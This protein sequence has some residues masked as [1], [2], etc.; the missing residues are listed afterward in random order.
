[1][2]DENN[3]DKMTQ[4]VND[5]NNQAQGD[6]LSDANTPLIQEI[7]DTDDPVFTGQ[8]VQ[9]AGAG[10][11]ILESIIETV[12]PKLDKT[13]DDILEEGLPSSQRVVPQEVKAGRTKKK[14]PEEK[15]ETK[16]K[17]TDPP[18]ET[19]EVNFVKPTTPDDFVEVLKRQE[20]L[21][22]GG[23]PVTSKSPTP[24]QRQKGVVQARI[25]TVNT[26]DEEKRALE[27]AAYDVLSK[28]KSFKNTTVE[29]LHKSA[30]E[31]GL[32]E[33]EMKRITQGLPLNAKIGDYDLSK[34]IAAVK[35]LY[36]LH[37]EQVDALMKKY[38]QGQNLGESK[39][40][41]TEEQYNLMVGMTEMA[42][43][44]DDLTQS[45]REIG[46]ALNA[47]KDIK[48]LGPTVKMDDLERVISQEMNE[49]AFDRFVNLYENAGNDFAR[50]ALINQNGGTFRHLTDSAYYTFQSNLLNN[51]S[52]WMDNFIGSTI[53]GGLMM[54]EDAVSSI[55]ISPLTNQF[56]RLRKKPVPD[57][58]A[59][60]DDVLTGLKGFWAGIKDG[61]QGAAHVIRT[62]E[63]QG[64]KGNRYDP[65]SSSRIP[66]ELKINNPLTQATY[67]FNTSEL[68]DSWVGK[69]IDGIGFLQ[70]IPMKALAAGDEIVG[71]TIARMALHKEGSIY[72]KNR[73]AQLRK[74][75]KTDEEIRAI[76]TPEVNDFVN[77]QPADIFAN[78][79]EHKDMIQFT[80]KWDKTM[81]LDKAYAAVNKTL[82]NPYIRFMVPFANTLTKIFDQGASRIPG[83]NFIS[84]QF[85]K[86]VTRGGKHLDRA[87]SR[88]VVGGTAL[89]MG[90]ERASEGLMTGSGPAN[91]TDKAALLKTGWQPYSFVF[92]KDS[93]P[94][95]VL[96]KIGALTDIS[97]GNGKIYISYQRFD[98]IAPIMAGAADLFD[99]HRLAGEDVTREDSDNLF[100]ALALSNAE[101][102]QNLPVMQ[103]VS[104][105]T[106]AVGGRYEDQGEKILD[107]IERMTIAT[108]RNVMLSIPGVGLTQS[109]AARNIAKVID[110]EHKSK[111][112]DDPSRPIKYGKDDFANEVI[113]KM[114][115]TVK[116]STPYFR[117]T[118]ENELDNAGRPIYNL[119]TMHEHW[120]NVIPSMRMT[121]ER[122]SPMDEVLAENY[123]GI[124]QAS[125]KLDSGVEMSAKQY[126]YYKRLYGQKL[127]LPIAINLEGDEEMM[128]MEKAIVASVKLLEEEY[129]LENPGRQ[130]P[131]GE[132]REEIDRVVAMYRQEARYQILGEKREEEDIF[133]STK[134]TR[135]EGFYIDENGDE[136]KVPF[137]DLVDKVNQTRQKKRYSN[138]R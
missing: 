12:T 58:I 35:G 129:K 128:N 72:V 34:R 78:V 90:Y 55:L 127:K 40:L 94:H 51:P 113:D 130:L 75:G 38:K 92:E 108:G 99:M 24:G 30:G 3:I 105:F 14:Q 44:S 48:N 109:S 60:F 116:E 47:F 125:K 82:N 80:Y 8:E 96:K 39:P 33:E 133:T 28:N 64:Y 53:H 4:S 131:V 115:N 20:E 103:F 93:I 138:K 134:F 16:L 85:Y 66:D 5:L 32:H 70:S 26:A 101:F 49:T 83:L 18:P 19:P 36:T 114:M 59:E 126:N 87:A 98:M 68:K 57:D 56:R 137:P 61:W 37:R 119:G 136:R 13:K 74:Q 86:D 77:T 10:K 62:G 43:I 104:E 41:T 107:I 81:M 95:S 100:M 123:Y 135:Y 6:V 50:N 27:I 106:S 11:K 110:R 102:L 7:S 117:G 122:S 52:T 25:N 97:E 69:M 17:P 2:I 9:T 46:T 45:G 79:K 31:L 65:I 73:V 71:N 23:V 15:V 42:R 63:R 132:A 1:M 89:G 112:A 121:Q 118:L 111:L 91:F 54:V 76:V 124:S 29:D 22:T 21:L 84:P 120:I 67:R 88:L